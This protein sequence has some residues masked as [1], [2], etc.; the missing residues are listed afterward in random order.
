MQKTLVKT[1]QHKIA[2]VKFESR[3]TRNRHEY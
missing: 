3:D 1:E 2:S